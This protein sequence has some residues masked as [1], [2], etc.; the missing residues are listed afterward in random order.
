MIG[1]HSLIHPQVFIGAHCELGSRCEIHPHVTIGSD[2]FSFAPTKT[3]QLVKIPQIGKVIIGNDVEIGANCT[4]DRAALTV[5]RIGNGTKFDNLCHVAHN[6][7]IGENCVFAAGFKVAGSSKIGSNVMVGGD[8]S[9][10]DH[11]TIGDRIVIGGKSGVHKDLA[12]PGQFAG[13]PI[14]PMRDAMKTIANIAQ[15]TRIRKNLARVMK[16]LNIEEN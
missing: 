4:I 11:V 2:G 5:T 13:Y 12:G 1:D 15:L 3:G 9:V 14:E 16:H 7:E 6:V 10:S 8:T